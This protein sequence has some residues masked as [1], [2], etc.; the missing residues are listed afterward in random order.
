[1]GIFG[2]AQGCGGWGV[3]EAKRAAVPKIC[4]TYPAIMNLDGVISYLRKIKKNLWITWHTPWFLLTSAFF[5][6]KSTT[7]FAM[8][9]NTDIDCILIHNL[10]FF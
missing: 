1:M 3:G 5:Y 6:R 4:H 7:N 10:W 9:R 2:A 8:S